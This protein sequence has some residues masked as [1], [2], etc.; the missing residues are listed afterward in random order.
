MVELSWTQPMCDACW[1][2]DPYNGRPYRMIDRDTEICAWCGKET[3]SGI[4]RRED[5]ALVP[6]P[7]EKDA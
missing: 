3:R 2:A 1:E 7:A 6:Y 4:Y 5:P